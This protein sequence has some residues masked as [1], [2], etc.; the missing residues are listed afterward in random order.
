MKLF[1]R[2]WIQGERRVEQWKE[3]SVG[4][5]SLGNSTNI[6]GTWKYEYRV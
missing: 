3:L 2:K 6:R 4:V 5:H 1:L